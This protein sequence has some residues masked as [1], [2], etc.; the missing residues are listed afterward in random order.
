MC[1]ALSEALSGSCCPDVRP[2]LSCQ[3]PCPLRMSHVNLVSLCAMC[4]FKKIYKQLTKASE[5]SP[6]TDQGLYDL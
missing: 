5:V 1:V 4:A 2:L 6:L 3:V